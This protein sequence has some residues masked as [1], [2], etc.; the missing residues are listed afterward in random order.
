MYDAINVMVAAGV[1]ERSGDCISVTQRNEPTSSDSLRTRLQAKKARLRA[2]AS[3]Y[4]CLKSL[5]IRNEKHPAAA[6]DRLPL[7]FLV[8]AMP[9]RP[10]VTV[11][12]I[13]I[14]IVTDPTNRC[15]NL[16]ASSPCSLFGDLDVL[17][18]LRLPRL[19]V[20]PDPVPSL[21]E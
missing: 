13:Q 10:G 11:T 8:V 16:K 14:R 1:F 5:T 6:G 17:H 21:Y 4:Q 7:P 15:I 20:L 18:R 3:T 19:A 2:L 12:Y 9:D